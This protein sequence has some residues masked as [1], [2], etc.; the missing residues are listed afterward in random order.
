MLGKTALKLKLSSHLNLNS[1]QQKPA[2]HF[3]NKQNY[4]A[5]YIRVKPYQITFSS[6]QI[7]LYDVS[8]AKALEHFAKLRPLEIVQNIVKQ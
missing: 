5:R 1:M 8:Q 6:G 4:R 2:S 3:Q 7:T